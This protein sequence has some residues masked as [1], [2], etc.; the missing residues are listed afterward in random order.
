MGSGGANN[1]LY[2]YNSS[3][4]DNA[5]VSRAVPQTDR[6][7]WFINSVE[8]DITNTYNQYVYRISLSY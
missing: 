4:Y 5:F 7:S 3:R 1:E 8:E 6:I 2:T